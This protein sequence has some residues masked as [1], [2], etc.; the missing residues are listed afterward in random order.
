MLSGPVNLQCPACGHVFMSTL[1][2][3]DGSE[4][5]PRCALVSSRTQYKSFTQTLGAEP[6]RFQKRV[7]K[8]HE[9]EQA[10]P[11]AQ[12]WQQ[13]PP[14]AIAQQPPAPQHRQPA[15]FTQPQAYPAPPVHLPASWPGS[16]GASQQGGMDQEP[17]FEP[18]KKSSIGFWLTVSALSFAVCGFTGLLAW[19]K[20]KQRIK[21][22]QAAKVAKADA[23]A[24][25]P[26]RFALPSVKVDPLE[27]LNQRVLTGSAMAEVDR[28]IK[29]LFNS[30]STEDRLKAV[31][32]PYTHRA[33]VAAMFEDDPDKPALVALTPI[34]NP[35][36]SLA[37]RQRMPMFKVVT[38][39]NRTGALAA[40]TA[41]DSGETVLQWE[42]FRETHDGDLARYIETKNQ[43]PRWFYVGLRRVHSF[44]LPESASGEF[45]AIDIDGSTDGSGHIVTY[46]AK[47]SPLGRH[48]ARNVEWN[49]F[50]FGRVLVSWMDIAGENRPALLDCEGAP[51]VEEQE[52]QSAPA[53]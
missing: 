15:Y 53:K 47:E 7:Q 17:A 6:V 44:D 51:A 34:S 31:S 19:E 25:S 9:P 10:A 33:E 13:P 32:D 38:S 22:L 46:V 16:G 1:S 37:T 12:A 36:L 50:Y 30:A 20:I 35:P 52:S 28:L 41:G 40:T 3:P 8:A 21:Y 23:P 14:A 48:F 5:C 27:E 2:R 18:K 45:D 11:A 26:G 42:L 49:K 29:V 24:T 39:K 43:Q 4:T